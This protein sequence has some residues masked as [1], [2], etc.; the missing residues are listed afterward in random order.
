MATG[1]VIT[2]KN[3]DNLKNTAQ[4]SPTLDDR[5]LISLVLSQPNNSLGCKDIVRLCSCVAVGS[6]RYSHD[7]WYRYLKKWRLLTR[8]SWQ[9]VKMSK[10]QE[11]SQSGG[12]KMWLYAANHLAS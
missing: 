8:T 6:L 12:T 5:L 3:A 10:C 7:P 11:L 2:K 9:D 1:V 4:G